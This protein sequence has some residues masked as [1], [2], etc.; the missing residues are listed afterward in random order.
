MLLLYPQFLKSPCLDVRFW[1]LL[2]FICLKF[3]PQYCYLQKQPSRGVPRRRCS[4]N[5][6]QI[7]MRTH[8]PKCDFN[9]SLQIY[10]NQTLA[11]RSPVNLQHMFRTLFP[12]N[13]SGWLLLWLFFAGR[14]CVDLVFLTK[15]GKKL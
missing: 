5:M 12:K 14:K 10:W 4:E 7:Y 13:T 15:E 6:Q 8:M 2:Y 11:W 3:N 9:N 1:D